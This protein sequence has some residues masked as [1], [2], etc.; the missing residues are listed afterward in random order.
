MTDRL[1]RLAFL[2]ACVAIGVVYGVYAVRL[3]SFPNP[4]IVLAESTVRDLRA[5]WRNDFGL[6]PTRHLVEARRPRAAVGE[7]TFRMHRPEAAQ[8]GL[9]LI[10]GL[11]RDPARSAHAVTLYDAAGR[12]AYDWPVD[13]ALL[14]PE[15]AKP[16]NV[17]LHGLRPL[18]DGSLIAAFDAGAVLARLDSCGRPLWT[19]GGGFH[20]S[21]EFDDAGM[22][23]SWRDEVIVRFDPAT[24]EVLRE[25]DLHDVIAADGGQHGA[26]A[27]HSAEE[28]SEVRYLGD[29]FHTNDVEPLTAA[30]A[31]RFPMFEPGD[32]LISLRELNLVAVIDADDLRLKWWQHG[33]WHRQHD[34]D[35][36]PDGTISVYDN[37]M[38]LGASRIVK[39]DPATRAVTTV[40]AGDAE[41][42]FYSYR[43]GKHQILPNGNV[44]VTESEAGRVF[45]AA[46]DGGLV[47]ERELDW[48]AERNLVVT[49]AEWL[50]ADFFEPGALDCAVSAG[51]APRAG[52]L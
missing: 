46:P 5:N 10:A 26:F 36:E 29:A 38:G 24:G 35:F 33:P 15:G 48:D 8:P 31:D 22:G 28:A 52:A 39:I 32:L 2:L 41:E 11:S 18:P 40:Y 34:P 47:W 27:I 50:P 25:I 37:R 12:A 4:Q 51:A 3:N 42:P 9:T 19:L 6:E 16:T 43:R 14:D 7:E 17:M 21:V 23:W 45:E 20:H 1:A 49:S 13:Y 30:H 44:L